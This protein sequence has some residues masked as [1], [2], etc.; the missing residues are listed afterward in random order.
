MG[1]YPGGQ[2]VDTIKAIVHEAR[3]SSRLGCGPAA[4]Q[5]LE[6]VIDSEIEQELATYQAC[7]QLAHFVQ[8]YR[9]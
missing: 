7:R 9:G 2:P 3:S 6:D 4:A 8:Q 1:S 5:A